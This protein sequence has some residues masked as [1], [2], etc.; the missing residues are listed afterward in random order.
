[1]LIQVLTAALIVTSATACKREPA[2]PAAARPPIVDVHSHFPPG[3]AARVVAIMD[4]FGVATVVNLSGGGPGR[5]LEQQLAAAAAHPGR[6]VVFATLDW[7]TARRGPG[8]GERLADELERAVGLG[9][10]GLKIAKGLG[11]AYRDHE[12]ALIPIDAAALDP[13][14]ARA[15]ALGVPV[16]IH[17]GDPVAFWQPLE[18]NERAEELAAH[19]EWSFHGAP[20]PSWQELVAAMERRIA[21]H[22]GTTFIAVH[23]G[24]APED[25]AR[26]GAMLERYPNLFV[27][28]AAR[29]PELGRH[30]PAAMRALLVRHQDRVLFGSDLGVGLGERDL[31]LGS[32]GRE[33]PTDADLDHFFAASFRWFETADQG[34]AHPTPI[35]GR[36]T[37][38]GVALPAD[39]RAAIYGENAARLFGLAWPPP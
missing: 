15:G 7:G 2:P 10:R 34:F 18:G 33:P 27:D 30:D 31:M 11:L 13:L 9:A 25:P 32:T 1:M 26:V 24:N 29:I 17:S 20:V 28:T 19:P 4:R 39:A 23:F 3:A 37:I 5:G 38:D 6:I 21:R 22:P 16:A 8:Y 36:W 35:Q 12:G 14:F